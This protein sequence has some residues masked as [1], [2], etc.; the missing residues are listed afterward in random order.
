KGL[1]TSTSG[2]AIRLTVSGA[3]GQGW[4]RAVLDSPLIAA[5]LRRIPLRINAPVTPSDI[6]SIGYGAIGAITN[7][8]AR[9]CAKA[10][11]EPIIISMRVAGELEDLVET[12]EIGPLTLKELAKPAPAFNAVRLRRPA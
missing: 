2:R 4:L 12:E 3:R 7:L 9:L 1:A 6:P 5:D 8:A 10:K 11:P